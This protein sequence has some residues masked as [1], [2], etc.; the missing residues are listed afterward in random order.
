[1]KTY[2]CS[3]NYF[4]DFVTNLNY[5]KIIKNILQKH[6]YSLIHKARISMIEWQ[7]AHMLRI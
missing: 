7:M 3:L 4:C 6:P 5:S 1:M 2:T